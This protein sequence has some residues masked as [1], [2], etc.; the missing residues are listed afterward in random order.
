MRRTLDLENPSNWNTIYEYLMA[1]PDSDPDAE[2]DPLSTGIFWIDRV[3]TSPI[4]QVW[5]TG[6][7]PT[8]WNWAG[9]FSIFYAA[10]K[11]SSIEPG[12]GWASIS[13]NSLWIGQKKLIILDLTF[14]KNG[15]RQKLAFSYTAPRWFDQ[16]FLH[17]SEYTGPIEDTD[18]T[19]DEILNNLELINTRLDEISL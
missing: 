10:P 2:Y 19:L 8:R 17:L 1:K 4:L 5:V 7:Y 16:A 6:D 11:L 3:P 12:E 18:D 9:R 14:D 15:D 13:D